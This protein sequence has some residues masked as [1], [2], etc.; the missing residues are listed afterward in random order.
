LTPENKL[1]TL[2]DN[3][4]EN[5]VLT[6]FRKLLPYSRQWD[7]ATGYFEIGALLDLDGLWQPLEGMRVLLGDEMTKR[8][9]E[10]LIRALRVQSEESIEAAKEKDDSL[11]GLGAVR[12]ALVGGQI[13]TRVYTKAKFH[14]KGYIM[15]GGA[16]SLTDFAVVGSSNFTHPGLTQNI[17]LNLFTTEQHQINALREWYAQVWKEG[18][19]VSAEVLKVIERHLG[20]VKV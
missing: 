16:N 1:P 4:G 5:K 9:R 3:R 6:A 19:D 13:Q 20:T 8:T 17:E 12:Q 11:A 18:E 10:E 15:D 7:V 2:L 14:A